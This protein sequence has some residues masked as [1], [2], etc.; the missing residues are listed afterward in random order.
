[1][2]NETQKPAVA[3]TPVSKPGVS[4]RSVLLDFLG[5]MNLAITILVIIAIAS[6]I[7]TVLQQNQ[8]YNS[9]IIKFGPFWHEFFLTLNL[10]DIYSAG[11]FLVLLLFLVISTGV[12][13]YR[14]TPTMLQD[15]RDFRLNSK[16]KSLKTIAG[17]RSWP[18]DDVAATEKNVSRLFE[19]SGYQVRRKQHDDRVIIAGMRG[20]WNRLGYIFAHLGI[21]VILIGGVMDSTIDIGLRETLGLSQVDKESKY[22]KD[23]PEISQLQPNDLLSFRGN[24]D[25]PEGSTANFALLRMREGT[26]VQYLPF[27]IQLKD[28][29]VEHYESGQ[30][31]SFESDL[32]IIDK[33]RDVKFE[34][35]IAVNHPLQYRGYTIYQASFGDGGSRLKFKIWPFYDHK[36]RTLDVPGIVDGKRVL[37][38]IRGDLTMEFINFKKYN[39]R[40]AMAGEAEG[41]KFI[42]DGSSVVFKVRDSSGVAK[43]Y[44]NY[45]SP[46]KQNDRYVFVSGMRNSPSEAYRFLHIPADDN[47]T[48]ERFMKFHALINNTKRVEQ[49]A[50]K[51][52]TRLLKDVPDGDKFKSAILNNMME[53]L[54]HFNHGGYE[55]IQQRIRAAN[56][57]PEESKKMND[58]YLNLLHTILFAIYS[59]VLEQEGID[60]SK[61]LTKE[62]QGFY[63]AALQSLHQLPAYG[64]PFYAQLSDFTHVESSGLSIAKL[65]GKNVF[66]LGSIV[67]IIGIFLLLYVSH[68]R[69]WAIFYKDESGQDVLL[70]AGSGNRNIADF[71]RYF[72]QLMEK[73]D[74]LLTGTRTS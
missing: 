13:I 15:M 20:R 7:G 58:A 29:R 38:T 14:N 36:L 69:L 42:N 65:P 4:R 47:F 37:N 32:V 68:Q 24:V 23:I 44:M 55:A 46:V 27:A 9:Y 54:S 17:S 56:K 72:Q 30:P 45:M 2:N 39:V 22:V 25:L 73:L 60:T 11:W 50:V 43:E 71:K 31:K 57:S 19:V 28:F 21:I 34:K 5:S 26:L 3:R 61:P 63:M 33:D 74:R 35:T 67:S 49:L 16:I 48:V 10:Y 6:A 59:D 53:L 12:C 64:T 62:Q 70:V 1:M 40:P 52:V 8:A 41:K 66:Y 18:V 51:E